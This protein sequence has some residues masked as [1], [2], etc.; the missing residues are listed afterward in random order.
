[1]KKAYKESGTTHT[2]GA[3]R[4]APAEP[5]AHEAA[6]PRR[7]AEPTR[8]EDESL[9]LVGDKQARD[10]LATI[11]T[12]GFARLRKSNNKGERLSFLFPEE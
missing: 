9:I 5:T 12:N 11:V 8:P 4:L 7:F 10:R 3:I 2:G 6:W 1:M